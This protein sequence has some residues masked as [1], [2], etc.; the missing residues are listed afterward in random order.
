M[1]STHLNNVVNAIFG[2]IMIG[3]GGIVSLSCDNRYIG[4]FL[5]GIGLFMIITHKYG[6]F[7]GKVGYVPRNKPPYLIEV[8]IALCGNCIGTFLA[9][10]LV[11]LTRIGT[12]L[13]ESA[14]AVMERKLA[15]TFQSAL[16]LSVFCG[17]LMF[18]A[19]E[20]NAVQTKNQNN[21]GAA[22]GIFLPVVTFIIC[23]FNHCVADM[24]YLFLSGV[25]SGFIPYFAVII[26]GNALGGMFIP[27]I[28]TIA[29]KTTP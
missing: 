17:I 24:F 25:K 11:R 2:G 5:F 20:T 21:L 3:I 8:F 28:Q 9:A 27:L 22:L 18:L 15:D 14:V 1:K 16:I 13:S 23:G 6:L 4:S 19:V 12:V 29:N 26:F 7:T 10:T